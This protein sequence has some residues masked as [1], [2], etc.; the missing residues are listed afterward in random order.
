M[1]FAVS[2]I[3]NRLAKKCTR[4]DACMDTIRCRLRGIVTGMADQPGNARSMIRLASRDES[5]CP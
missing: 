5:P 3:G 2:G 1:W 4:E